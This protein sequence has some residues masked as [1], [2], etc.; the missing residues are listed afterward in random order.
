M[1]SI[2][3]NTKTERENYKF[4]IGSII[5]RPVAF[6]T[7]LSEEG[8]LNGAPFSYF[9]I[10]SSNPPMISL[11]IQRFEGS[12]KDTARNILNSKEFVVHIVDEQNVEKMNLTAASLPPSQSEVQFA[13]LTP[14]ESVKVSVPGVKEAK[15]RMECVLEYSLELGVKHSDGCDFMIGRVVQYHIES[16][17]YENGK[18]DPKGLGAISRLAGHDYAKNCEKIN[19]KRTK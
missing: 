17:I 2:D 1:L 9:N 16:S 13:E 12:Q 6:V 11:S 15:V 5:P 3:P 14:V 18:I 10:V 8:V 19:R 7:S 4:L